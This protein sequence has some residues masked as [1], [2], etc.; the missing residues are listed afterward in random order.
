[1]KNYKKLQPLRISSNW[2]IEFNKFLNINPKKIL[3]KNKLWKYYFT[4]DI[5]LLK[6]QNKNLLIDLGWYPSSNPKGKFILLVIKNNNWEKPILKF[7]S[8][9]KNKIVKKIEKLISKNLN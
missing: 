9:N 8:R 5:L 1:M 3:K 2:S 7:S 6:N 4:E